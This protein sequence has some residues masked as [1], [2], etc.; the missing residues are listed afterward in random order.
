[1]SDGLYESLSGERIFIGLGS[2]M[3]ERGENLSTASALIEAAGIS[4]LAAAPVYE[5]DPVIYTRQERFYNTVLE[6][7]TALTPWELLDVLQGIEAA[8]GRTRDI[9]KGPRT[10]DLDILMLGERIIA[11]NRLTVPHYDLANRIFFLKPLYDIDS[12]LIIPR[13][14]GIS[15]LMEL[16]PQLDIKEIY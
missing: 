16:C 11:D 10:I 13:L 9:P 8:M 5:T 4:I 15:E 6:V 14:G 12:S 3:G 7:G 2:N 1:M